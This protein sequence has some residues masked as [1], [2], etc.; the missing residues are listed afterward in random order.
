MDEHLG[1]FT[2]H[3]VAHQMPEGGWDPFVS[4]DCFDTTS[5][6]FVLLIDKHRASRLPLP[7]Y[8]EAMEVARQEGHRLVREL[9]SGGLPR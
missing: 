9:E 5:H 1:K 8:E 4:V 7:S 2:L 6:D 3:F